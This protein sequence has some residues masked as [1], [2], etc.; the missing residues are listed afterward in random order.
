MVEWLKRGPDSDGYYSNQFERV[1]G[2]PL[3]DVWA[4][5]ITWEHTFKRRTCSPCNNIR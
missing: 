3:D 1:F 4:D 5:W 2:K